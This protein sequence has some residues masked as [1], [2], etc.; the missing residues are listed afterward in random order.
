MSS[1]I[2]AKTSSKTNPIAVGG[3]GG[4]GTRVVASFFE[5]LGFNM[6]SDVNESLDNLTFTLLFKR[7]ALL[8][9]ERNQ[10]EIRA[11][12]G[13]FIQAMTCDNGWDDDQKIHL[14]NIAAE[15]RGLQND[16]KLALRLLNILTPSPKH[17]ELAWGWKEPNTHLF[18]STLLEEIPSLRYVHVLRNGLDM[19]YNANLAQ[20][21]LWGKWLLNDGS[22]QETPER[23][24]QFWCEANRRVL[25]LAER[26]VLAF[27]HRNDQISTNLGSG[28]GGMQLFRDP[29]SGPRPWERAL[30]KKFKSLTAKSTKVHVSSSQ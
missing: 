30:T 10:S 13:Y 22:N 5:M 1:K 21:R 14:N 15:S 7:P 4:S 26:Y 28:A 6:G 11:C 18:L 9:I 3:V 24:F 8:P 23:A 19:A 27:C 20:L 29:G 17:A 16:E 25:A 2:L 12:I